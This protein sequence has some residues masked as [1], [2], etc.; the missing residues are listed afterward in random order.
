[1]GKFGEG[2]GDPMHRVDI[3]TEFVVSAAE[4]LD[5]CVPGTDYVR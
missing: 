1:V 5:E 4:V 3:D 2:R